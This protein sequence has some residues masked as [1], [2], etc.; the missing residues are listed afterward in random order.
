MRL[1]LLG[2]CA[3]LSLALYL[4]AY[5]LSDRTIWFDEAFSYCMVER[6]SWW[7]MIDR[8]GRDVHPP[9]YYIVLRCW[10]ACVGTSPVGL[11]SLSVAMGGATIIGF[12]FFCRDVFSAGC[13]DKNKRLQQCA[14]SAALLAALLIAVSPSHIRWSYEARMYTLTTALLAFST[15]ML[16]RAL[17]SPGA[18]GGWWAAYCPTAT[19]MLYTHNYAIFSFAAQIICVAGYFCRRRHRALSGP[20][21]LRAGGAFAVTI[22]IYSPW[23]EV[24]LRQKARVQTDYWI[25][26]T[27]WLSVP[28]AWMSLLFPHNSARSGS[29]LEALATAGCLLAAIAVFVLRG[30]AGRWLVAS[31]IVL[32]VA[33]S[34][35][36]SFVSV[37]IIVDR[38]FILAYMFLLC[39]AARLVAS[40]PRIGSGIALVLLVA[41][42]GAALLNYN[43]SVDVASA[44]GMRGA[45]EYIMARHKSGEPIVVLHPCIYLS[46]RYY[47]RGTATHLYA[48]H[49]SLS[50]YTGG[51]VLREDDFWFDD[52]LPRRRG[53]LIWVIDTT[54]LR[55][56]GTRQHLPRCWELRGDPT[57]YR[58][59]FWFEGEVTVSYY[60]RRDGS[61]SPPRGSDQSPPKAQPA[62]GGRR[63]NG[64][65][66]RR[67]DLWRP[68]Q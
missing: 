26:P 61:A 13:L 65:E 28:Q 47:A 56:P 5:H 12:Y 29:D 50:H 45:M 20:A 30:G 11:R 17:H 32:P 48:T 19:A 66:G 68:A 23:V 8:T 24:L 39:G 37:A 21:L 14:R 10:T 33:L 58:A 44:P 52:D 3:I 2:L 35:I 34:V 60:E 53:S 67:R 54:G 57:K 42:S 15:W 49:L 40:M 1:T 46:A 62:V 55:M 59:P 63:G 41:E 64:A 9:F 31:M 38:Y 25:Q 18:V 4:R 43:K 36:V 51:P 16:V 27:G 6:F 7:E 22:A